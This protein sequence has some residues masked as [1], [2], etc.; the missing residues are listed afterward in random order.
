MD[1]RVG[2]SLCDRAVDARVCCATCVECLVLAATFGIFTSPLASVGHK[3]THLD[4]A[5][6]RYF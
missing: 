3:G 6:F 5:H 2:Q 1:R 4:E